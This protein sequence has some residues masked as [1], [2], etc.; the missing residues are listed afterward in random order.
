MCPNWDHEKIR[1]DKNIT[2][3]GNCCRCNQYQS[4]NLEQN[5]IEKKEEQYKPMTLGDD[6]GMPFFRWDIY[7]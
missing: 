1:F 6:Q 3:L 7:W 2:R 5:H 4:K